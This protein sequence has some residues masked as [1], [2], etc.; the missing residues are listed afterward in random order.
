[1]R[2]W[3]VLKELSEDKTKVYEDGFGR[4]IGFVNGVLVYTNVG[5][6]NVVYGILCRTENCPFDDLEEEWVE[7]N[8][9]KEEK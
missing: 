8:N 9:S 3:D 5:K 1:M 2:I 6:R 4:R 7:V